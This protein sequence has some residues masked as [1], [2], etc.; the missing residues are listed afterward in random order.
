MRHFH[1]H[2]IIACHR[3]HQHNQSQAF[4]KM[5]KTI[6]E[7]CSQLIDPVFNAIKTCR[8]PPSD[9]TD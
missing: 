9:E 3:R 2:I 8:N 7:I 1:V 6:R 5:A 4:R